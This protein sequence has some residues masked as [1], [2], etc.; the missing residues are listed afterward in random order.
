MGKVRVLHAADLH[1]DTAFDGL[2][3]ALAA[4]RRAEL[5]EIPEKLVRLAERVG[6]QVVLLPGDLFDGRA[7]AEAIEAVER[8]LQA[9]QVPVFIAPGNHDFYRPGCVYDKMY[10]P[11]HVHVF[12]ENQIECV[13]V[14]ELDLRVWG[15]AFTDS[16]CRP[17]LAEFRPPEKHPDTVDL[18]CVHGV[19]AADGPYNP[20]T[21][22]QLAASGMDY[23]ALGH[24]HTCSG[25]QRAGDTFY[26]WPGV[27]MGRGFDET[28]TKGV[29]VADVEPGRVTARFAPLGGREYRILPVDITGEDPLTAIAGALPEG[30]EGDIV[31]I[32]LTGTADIPPEP[33]TIRRS[34]AGRFFHTEVRSQVTVRQDLWARAGEATLRG[35]FLRALKGQMT[36]DPAGDAR[37]EAAAQWGLAALDGREEAEQL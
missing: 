3:D 20:I 23:A 24:S 25:L 27:P 7:G 13:P 5:R 33:E 37:I 35:A 16:V 34:L 29:V 26:L 12:R 2:P 30:A 8:M 15:G 1:L 10:L 19:V 6:A 22:E 31:R 21:P 14:P 18:L 9:L 4:R 17:L 36:G 28:G 32:V 11:E